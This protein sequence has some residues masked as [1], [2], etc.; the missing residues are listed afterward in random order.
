MD[1]RY[2]PS[3]NRPL[4]SFPKI[5]GSA[6]IVSTTSLLLPRTFPFRS[7]LPIPPIL[8]LC[9][10]VRTHRLVSL[11]EDYLVAIDLVWLLVRWCDIA[12]IHDPEHDLRRIKHTETRE[13]ESVDD[14][15]NLS[16]WQKFTRTLNLMTNCRGVGWNWQVKNIDP[17]TEGSRR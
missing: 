4:S 16:R 1:P 8:Y 17:V 14:I 6:Y 13:L 15:E 12:V 2:F 3:P 11:A 10:H 7:Y 9:Y 5:L